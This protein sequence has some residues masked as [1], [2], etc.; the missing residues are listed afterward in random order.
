M[1][2]LGLAACGDDVAAV[3]DIVIPGEHLDFWYGAANPNPVCGG[4]PAWL[5]GYVAREAAYL[6]LPIDAPRIEYH[7]RPRGTPLPCPGGAQGCTYLDTGDIY[8][9]PP[10]FLHEVSH[11]V[12]ATRGVHPASFFDEG[13][14]TAMSGP[15]DPD[16]PI[17]Y[18]VELDPLLSA[19]QLPFDAYTTA[20]DFTSYLLTTRG[21][22]LFVEL[23]RRTHKGDSARAVRAAFTD[24]YGE[25]IDDAIAERRA[26]P[27][28]FAEGRIN[29]PM[30]SLDP[31]P[32]NTIDATL[33]CDVD[34]G[35]IYGS[36][37]SM[38]RAFA[39]FDVPV[40]G[41]YTFGGQTGPLAVAI[42]YSCEGRVQRAFVRG[43]PAQMQVTLPA[44]RLYVEMSTYVANPSEIHVG[45]APSGSLR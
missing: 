29:F 30:C 26:D 23:M 7:Y 37:P 35:P 43:G 14:A 36:Y 11:A 42:L 5:D 28:V 34:D 3:D 25:T 1:L 40:A 9:Q 41:D 8:A 18:D 15:E 19:E 13:L 6:G 33:D 21:T 2:A 10:D 22:A 39:S 31:A 44:G 45:L 12:L 32:G 20:A 27:I 24:V 38:F 4:T 17:S 16:G